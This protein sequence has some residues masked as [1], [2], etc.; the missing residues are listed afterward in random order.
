MQNL[1]LDFDK[2]FFRPLDLIRIFL[3]YIFT[4]LRLRNHQSC[5]CCGR[6]QW[7]CW[8]VKDEIWNKLPKKYQNTALCLE[9]FCRLVPSVRK[10][11]FINIYFGIYQ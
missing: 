7:V 11:D 10:K 2:Y 6:D 8:T 3:K 9:C 5:K 4:R 1:E